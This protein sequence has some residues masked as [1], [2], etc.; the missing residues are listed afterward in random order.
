MTRGVSWHLYLNAHTKPNI[1]NIPSYLRLP[2]LLRNLTECLGQAAMIHHCV[3]D[4]WWQPMTTM[5]G[6]CDIIICDHFSD[7]IL[8]WTW[9][10]SVMNLITF[11]NQI[12]DQNLWSGSWSRHMIKKGKPWPYFLFIWHEKS[13][14][15]MDESRF[16]DLPWQWW[17]M[18][19][20]LL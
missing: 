4:H 16:G 5:V 6:M 1:D 17:T 13:S 10:H 3:G 20:R 19:R 11:F 2:S 7:H 15:M 12:C 14:S 9:S 8:W 18:M